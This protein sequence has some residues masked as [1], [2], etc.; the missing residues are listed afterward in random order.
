MGVPQVR[1][2]RRYNPTSKSLMFANNAGDCLAPEFPG[3]T[4]LVF[5][6]N[7]PWQFG[8]IVAVTMSNDDW[9]TSHL[10]SKQISLAPDRRTIVLLSRQ[11]ALVLIPPM[12]VVGT[13]VASIHLGYRG[14]DFFTEELNTRHADFRRETFAQLR[15]RGVPILLADLR[16]Y[17]AV[18]A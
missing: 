11:P 17:A 7:V 2:Y 12:K 10:I 16:R 6:K 18:A 15:K 5:D 9:R 4:T 8:D 14:P 13:L 1:F 3:G